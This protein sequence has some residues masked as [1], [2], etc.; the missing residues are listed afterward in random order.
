MTDR[1]VLTN[2]AFE[3]RHGVH[4]MERRIAQRFEVDVELILDL[5]PAG[6]TDTLADTVDYAAVHDAVAAV[7]GGASVNLLETLAERIAERILTGFD[8][9]DGVVVRVR[10]PGVRLGGPLD[11]ASVE[12]RRDR[13]PDAE[14][15]EP[16]RG[17]RRP[18]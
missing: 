16:V 8:R 2:L 12:I 14:P 17:E 10:K 1:I 13:R 7:V 18:A 5:G 6:R 3:A 11:H 9:V 15:P 4:E